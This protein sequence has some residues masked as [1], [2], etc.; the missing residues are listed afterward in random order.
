[1]W[2]KALSGSLAVFLLAMALISLA[3]TDA[4]PPCAL[5][6]GVASISFENGAPPALLRALRERVGELVPPGG[7]FDATDVV[8][9]GKNRR[10][11]FVWN[12]GTRWIV[13]TEHGG[14]GYNDP[15]FLYDLSPESHTATLVL[16]RI[17][18]PETVCATA[19]RLISF[20]SQKP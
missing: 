18:F 17:A 13:A 4:I 6:N 11:I 2:T 8:V 19:T 9:T 12:V 10:L 3:R 5:P 14:R 15:I 20:E 7:R 1:M 16:E